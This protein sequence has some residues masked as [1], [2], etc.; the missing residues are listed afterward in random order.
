MVGIGLG[1]PDIHG[2]GRIRGKC[3]AQRQLRIWPRGRCR[4]TSFTMSFDVLPGQL[5]LVA[6]KVYDFDCFLPL[7]LRD[8]P[9]H[10]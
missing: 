7:N 5:R 6:K 3:K 10:G 8:Y 4:L 9:Q 2:L 1:K